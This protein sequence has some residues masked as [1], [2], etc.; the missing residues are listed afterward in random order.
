MKWIA[1]LALA[2]TLPGCA[3]VSKLHTTGVAN[4]TPS[5]VYTLQAG[6]DVVREGMVVYRQ[7]PW[8]STQQPA[9]CQQ[10]SVALQIQKADASAMY[11]LANLKKVSDSGDRLHLMEAYQ[12]AQLAID[13][14]SRIAE[15]YGAK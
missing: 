7:L 2:L 13:S 14:A 15:I 11:A 6:Y 4:V 3:A 8:C 12:A 5:Q 1:V 10:K 9:P